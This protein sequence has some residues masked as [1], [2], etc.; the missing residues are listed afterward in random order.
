MKNKTDKD[1][2]MT[3]F[4]NTI[5]KLSILLVDQQKDSTEFTIYCYLVNK[6]F[7]SLYAK[8]SV[9]LLSISRKEQKFFEE[10]N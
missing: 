10:E 4:W 6:A 5:A 8:R 9:I 1:K 7:A 3:D 2:H